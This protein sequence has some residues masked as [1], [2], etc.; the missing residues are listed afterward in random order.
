MTQARLVCWLLSCNMAEPVL[1][2]PSIGH[3]AVR[4]NGAMD[5]G[6]SKG[7]DAWWGAFLAPRRPRIKRICLV[8]FLRR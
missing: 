6:L 3:S 1:Q 8:S 5:A 2:L 7:R 4:T